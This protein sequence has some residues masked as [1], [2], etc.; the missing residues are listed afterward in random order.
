VLDPLTDGWHYR[1][2]SAKLDPRAETQRTLRS[3]RL[4][5]PRRRGAATPLRDF[6]HALLRLSWPATIGFIAAGYCAANLLFACAYLAIGGVEHARPGSLRDAFYFSVQTMGTIGYGS[7]Y[8]ATDGAN[9]LVVVES[10]VGLVLTALATG[11]VFAKFSRPT[12]RLMFSRNVVL[13]PMNGVPTLAFRIGNRRT[14]HI[15]EAHVRVSIMRTER[16]TEGRDFYRTTDLTLTR[17]RLDLTRSWNVLHVV[18]ETSPLFRDTPESLESAG[19]ELL[20]AVS[21]T[22]DTWMQTIHAMHRYSA[23]QVVWGYRLT[24][25]MSEQGDVTTIDL[26]KFHDIEPTQPLPGFPYPRA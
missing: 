6:Y 3:R 8:P 23:R 16:T 2:D 5:G 10:T 21:G 1:P 22:D 7:M 14:N 19:A 26:S 11:L 20:V 17:D 4:R 24:D 9:L 15:F 18:D 25:V 12:A 13:S